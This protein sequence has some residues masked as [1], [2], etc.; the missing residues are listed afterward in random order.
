LGPTGSE[1]VIISETENLQNKRSLQE[2]EITAVPKTRSA[3][4]GVRIVKTT[5]TT[6]Q[7]QKQKQKL[8]IKKYKLKK[9]VSLNE[10]L[11]V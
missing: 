11:L 10:L 1:G 3:E 8:Q 4:C 6:K 5:T 7:N 9:N 2:T